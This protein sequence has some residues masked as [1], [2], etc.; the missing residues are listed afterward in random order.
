M[1]GKVNFVVVVR[2][3]VLE[4]LAVPEH[5]RWLEHD[6]NIGV[7]KQSKQRGLATRRPRSLG[8]ERQTMTL[9]QLERSNNY[10]ATRLWIK[11]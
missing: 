8:D 2:N 1:K 6:K 10:D 4:N 3:S 11:H 9:L 7:K 5:R